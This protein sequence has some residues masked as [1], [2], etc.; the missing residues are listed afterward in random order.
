MPNF[1]FKS[2]IFRRI[3]EKINFVFGDALKTNPA[4]LQTKMG[5]KKKAIKYY[6]NYIY[7]FHYAGILL[8]EHL[9]VD[10][11]TLAIRSRNPRNRT[12]PNTT[13][14]NRRQITSAVDT[15]IQ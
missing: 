13:G 7:Q 4:P 9:Q 12:V 8:S 5:M 14:L 3:Y 1:I 2:K 15:V 11:G 6:E 10:L